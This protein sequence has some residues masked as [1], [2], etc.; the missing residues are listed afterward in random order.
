MRPEAPEPL[1][2]PL[3]IA[4]AAGVPLPRVAHLLGGTDVVV[5]REDAVRLGRHLRAETRRRLFSIFESQAVD[6]SRPGW[7]FAISSSVHGAFV[8]MLLL[9]TM[10]THGSTAAGLPARFDADTSRLVFITSPGP[11]G[12][13]GGGGLRQ[14][15]P[16]PKARR[17][18]NRSMSSPVPDRRPPEPVAATEPIEPPL[19][20]EP[21]PRVAAPVIP[22]PA[23]RV[24]RTGVPD[25]NERQAE[26]QGTGQGGG[27]GT[28]AGTGVGQGTGSGIGDGLGGGTGGGPYRPG[29]GIEPPRLVKE[30]KPDFSDEARR[31]GLSGDVLLEIVVRRDGSVGEVRIVRPLGA[32]LDERAVRAVRAWRFAP[33]RRHGVAV[34][35]VVEVSVEFTLR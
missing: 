33:A 27:A 30:V 4:L 28:G 5:T 32:G 22:S 18:G 23:D 9:L 17:E 20:A 34:D 35:V 1:Y 14:P 11:G 19:A 21:L 2:T 12:G 8:A 16:A 25:D 15:L 6:P 3:E 7:P 24:D 29:S 26:S 13:G 31:R 10:F